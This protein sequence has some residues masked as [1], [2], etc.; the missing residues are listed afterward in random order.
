VVTV[1]SAG[2]SCQSGTVDLQSKK[3]WAHRA[4]QATFTSCRLAANQGP[5]QLGLEFPTIHLLQRI[6]AVQILIGDPGN[7]IPSSHGEESVIIVIATV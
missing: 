3:E 1:L 6:V 2:I 7:K 5:C 4:Q